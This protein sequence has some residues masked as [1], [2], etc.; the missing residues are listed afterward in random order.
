MNTESPLIEAIFT[1]IVEP[2]TTSITSIT[3]DNSGLG[4]YPLE[5]NSIGIITSTDVEVRKDII[6]E[7]GGGIGS[8]IYENGYNV[9]ISTSTITGQSANLGPDDI[10]KESI[11][12]GSLSPFIPTKETS[13][14]GI[15]ARFSVIITYD[16]LGQPLSESIVLRDGGSGYSV[17]D[18]V[19]IAGTFLGGDSP[20]N[21]ISFVV[22]KVSNT[23]IESEN[24]KIYTN[25]PSNTTVGYGSGAIFDVTR[26]EFG[27]ISNVEVVIGGDNYQLEDNVSTTGS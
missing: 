19:S 16:N 18:T 3:V 5:P 1:V 25:I 4:Y 12:W 27:D 10:G 7:V 22:S 17:G 24:N 2:T 20:L 26:D 13:G 6:M 11:H 14:I 8:A 9:A 21:D 15:G 23:R